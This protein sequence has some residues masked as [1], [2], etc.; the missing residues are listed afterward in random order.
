VHVSLPNL[1]EAIP[2]NRNAAR[3]LAIKEI[4]EKFAELFI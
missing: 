4:A 2:K 3:D 1:L